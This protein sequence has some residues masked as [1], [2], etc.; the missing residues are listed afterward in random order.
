M[1][2]TCPKCNARYNVAEEVVP[3]AGR[4]ARCSVCETTWW[5]TP[6]MLDSFDA[7]PSKAEVKAKL[8]ALLAAAEKAKKAA[9]P[10]PKEAARRKA[11]GRVNLINGLA[12]V[13]PWLLAA[14]FLFGALGSAIIYRSEIVKIWP[15]TATI[16]AK[17]GLPAN[18][19][20]V[21]IQSVSVTTT[22][23]AKGPR[24]E[25]KGVLKSVSREPEFV[26]YLKL[27]L[28][29]PAGNEKLSWMIDPGIE[30]LQPGVA[31]RFSSSRTN[32]VRGPL[33]AVLVF[34]EPPR[35]GPASTLMPPPRPDTPKTSNASEDAEGPPDAK[36]KEAS[37]PAH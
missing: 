32:P 29:D 24:I 18:L 19:Y 37:N 26:P 13:I 15:K 3:P 31:H 9:K 6:P 10:G 22:L 25:V 5:A 14:C 11:Q 28:V 2:L 34:A 27:T 16:F 17:L 8:A 1:Q 33:N 30:V 21:D 12:I 23:E 7:K 20:G 36:P 4:T 35:K